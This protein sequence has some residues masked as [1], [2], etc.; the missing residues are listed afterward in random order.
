VEPYWSKLL[1]AGEKIGQHIFYTN[2]DTTEVQSA[3]L[4][5]Y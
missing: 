2:G 4:E 5:Q 1:G 3:Q